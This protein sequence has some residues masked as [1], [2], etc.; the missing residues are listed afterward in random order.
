MVCVMKLASAKFFYE[1]IY[2]NANV[3]EMLISENYS[4]L[5]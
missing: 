1:V 2:Y 3:H 5:R 4:H